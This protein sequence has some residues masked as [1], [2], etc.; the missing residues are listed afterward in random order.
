[1]AKSKKEDIDSCNN[2]EFATWLWE[3][4][5]KAQE[6]DSRAQFALRK[7]FDSVVQCAE[8]LN[9]GREAVKLT[10]IGHGI[11]DKLQRRLLQHIADGNL[12]H[13]NLNNMDDE[14]PKDTHTVKNNR[15]SKMITKYVPKFRSVS[16]GVLLSLYSCPCKMM[17]KHEIIRHCREYSNSVATDRSVSLSLKVLVDKELVTHNLSLSSFSLTA[18]GKIATE[19][20]WSTTGRDI[21]RL[22]T[23]EAEDENFSML[24]REGNDNFSVES[25]GM[26]KYSIFLF[27]DT[28]EV[29]SKNDR[30][31]L[32]SGLEELKV[33]VV[34]TTLVLGDFAF[35]ARNRESCEDIILDTIIERKTDADLI[36]SIP[37]GRYKEQK[38]RLRNCGFKN[39]VYLLEGTG[40]GISVS[41]FGEDKYF[42][43]ISQSVFSDDFFVKRCCSMQDTIQF[44]SDLFHHISASF[45]T[46]L[47]IFRP[48]SVT[49]RI[50]DVFRQE[51][52]NFTNLCMPMDLFSRYNSKGAN[53]SFFEVYIQQLMCLRG[54]SAEK[55]NV[56]AE[57]YDCYDKLIECIEGLN[58]GQKVNIKGVEKLVC[59]FQ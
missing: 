46:G 34:H 12:W 57:E 52:D 38:G 41:N 48:L 29:Y 5:R 10:G 50:M 56:I 31:L 45:Q 26:D 42:A 53:M 33:P 18:E 11:S 49:D 58:S 15:K 17:T 39:V 27:V 28:R 35:V 55:A 16:Y 59:S 19:K 36:A 37:D 51:Q 32:L 2:P 21:K 1:M 20:L 24:H 4:Y 3:W 9:T 22:D 40:E 14:A 43:A 7:A 6:S 13:Y 25:W 44:L 8:K 54:I 30:D 47:N 23:S